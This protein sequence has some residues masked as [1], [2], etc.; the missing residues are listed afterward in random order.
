MLRFPKSARILRAFDFD[1][2][3]TKGR[4]TRS[5]QFTIAWRKAARQ[6]LGIVVSRRV[7][8]AVER[9]RIKRVVRDFFRLNRALF[10]SGDTVVI[11]A[12]G[13]ARLDNS[14]LRTALARAL[15]RTGAAIVTP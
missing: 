11:A 5:G 7:G 2:V 14:G 4:R 15:E 10:P 9:N 8:C 12:P 6:R 3:K 1:E 13:A